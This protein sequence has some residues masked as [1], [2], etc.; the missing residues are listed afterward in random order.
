M[1]VR[2]ICTFF[3]S[4]RRFMTRPLLSREPSK[5]RTRRAVLLETAYA[6]VHQRGSM[7]RTDTTLE[8]IATCSNR[9]RRKCRC[10]NEIGTADH[11]Y[12]KIGQTLQP[13]Y[14]SNG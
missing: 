3:R 6:P 8:E 11:K 10:L 4:I 13:Q 9:L 5:G 7:P 2:H 1:H 12:K 14:E